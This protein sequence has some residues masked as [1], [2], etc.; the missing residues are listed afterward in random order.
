MSIHKKVL[1]V[2][3]EADD[4]T[5]AYAEKHE[6][7]VYDAAT[8]LILA[9][10]AA[11]EQGAVS[12]AINKL[13]DDPPEPTEHLIKMFRDSPT[14]PTAEPNVLAD[15]RVISFAAAKNIT[16]AAAVEWMIDR[17]DRRAVNLATYAEKKK[18]AR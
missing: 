12:E 10:L 9:G 18:A 14:A 17:A 15:P 11:S 5:R 13:V 16:P 1:R 3:D 6:I 7:G 4:K 2:T 8:A